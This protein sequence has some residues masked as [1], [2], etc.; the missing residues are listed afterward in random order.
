MALS[1]KK[2][3]GVSLSKG[4]KVSLTKDNLGLSKIIAGLGWDPAKLSNKNGIFGGLFSTGRPQSIDC[5]A[6]AV[7]LRNGKLSDMKDVVYF[8]SSNLIHSSGAVKHMGDNLTGEGDGDDEQ[9]MIDL[10]RLPS[11]IDK[12][13]LGVNIYRAKSKNQHFGMIDNAY[14]RLVDVKQ[15]KELY[16]YNLS[17]KY[18]SMTTVIFGELYK[19]NREWKFNPIGQGTHDGSIEECARRYR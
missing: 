15:D 12:I 7:L 1:I 5:D 2:R 14:I 13:I 19:Q 17:E 10:D 8:P 11:D 4:Q 9:I 18:D 6:F 3:R 16:Y